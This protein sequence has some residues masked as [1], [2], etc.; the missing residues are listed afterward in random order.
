[1]PQTLKKIELNGFKSFAQ[2]TSLEFADGITAIVGPNGSGKSNIID[3]IRWMLGERDA[4]NLRGGKIEDLIFAGTPK[5]PRLGQAQVSLIFDNRRKTLPLDFPEISITRQTN[6]G[7]VSQYF[8]NGDEVRLKDLAE[9]LAKARLGNK[10]LV[11]ITQ[12]NSDVFI[13]SSP[14][15]RREMIEEIL[16]LREFQIK[17][18]DAENKLKN[19]LI[20][21]DKAKALTE[22]ILPH[23]RSLKRQTSRW[24]KRGELESELKELENRFFGH[25]LKTLRSESKKFDREIEEWNKNIAQLEKDKSAAEERLKKVEAQRPAEQ[26][27]LKYV[28]SKRGDLFE[29]KNAIGKEIGSLE[30]Q[31]E[32]ADINKPS[33]NMPESRLM[34]SL[35]QKLKI[36]F[37][38]NID[39]DANKL[40][41][42]IQSALNEINGLLNSHSLAEA[43][44][45]KTKAIK[46]RLEELNSKLENIGQEIDKL[47][48]KERLLDKGQEEFYQNF[49]N[50]LREVEKIKDDI[51]KKISQK[52]Q[53]EFE[54]ERSSIKIQ[55]L[56][57]QISQI[58]RRLEEFEDFDTSKFPDGQN[59][60]ETLPAIE[61]RIL[62]LRGEL[63]NLEEIDENLLKEASETEKRYSFLKQ[64]TEDLIKASEDLKTLIK[65]L[66]EKIKVE[67]SAA[68]EKI[69]GEFGKFFEIMFGGGKAALKFEQPKIKKEKLDEE[70]APQS[71]EPDEEKEVEGGIEINISLPRKRI[72][73]LEVLSG[74]ERSLV[75]IAAL[76]ALISV[77]PPPFLV[78]DEADAALDERNAKRFAEILN[79]FSKETQFIIV[80]H[81]RTVMAAANILYGVTTGEDGTSKIIS[82]KLEQA[83][84]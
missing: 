10:G 74:G 31:L 26:E 3:A 66:N 13:K 46:S 34:F 24:E 49:K 83:D 57:R 40:K 82:L 25:Q 65:D 7:G 30:A 11:V 20:N 54:K 15:E 52:R 45:E 22:E 76:F 6:R 5:R 71:D 77:S 17:R 9:F 42:L 68:L 2:K 61:K 19:T 38:A 1:M 62:R 70:I 80:T 48:E 55:E 43:G 29:E 35:I 23:L 75:A 18:I 81:N 16:G 32:I 69:N 64:Q 78:L 44:R 8:L 79:E 47:N 58:N 50:V 27:E 39:K 14:Q 53:V 84:K 21:L 4:K 63:I 73:S 12:G 41:E 67:F 28:K 37:E 60:N 36:D 59:D 51:D 33:E 72:N 56:S